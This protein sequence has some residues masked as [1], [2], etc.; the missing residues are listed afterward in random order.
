VRVFVPSAM[1]RLRVV[2]RL[3]AG[4]FA[5]VWLAHDPDLDAPV[6]VKL[7]ADNWATDADVRRRFSDEARLLRRVDSDHLVRVY[8]VGELPDGRPYFVMT[9]ADAGN[10]A[11][12]LDRQP[13]PWPAAEVLRVVDAIAAGLAVLHEHGV[14]HRDLKPR[15]IL[16]RSTPDG[17]PRVLLGDLGIAKDLQWASGITMPAGSDGYMAPEQRGFSAQIG[18]ATDVH[19]LAVTAAQLLGLPGPPWPPTGVGQV[20]AAAT[21]HDPDARTA[22]PTAFAQQLRLAL[23]APPPGPY[24]APPG[25]YPPLPGPYPPPTNAYPPAAPPPP[26]SVSPPFPPPTDRG[27]VVVPREEQTRL[28]GAAT[29]AAG[30]T[31]VGTT[32][33]ARA[34]GRRRLLLVGGVVVLGL[35]LVAGLVGRA[36]LTRDRTLASPDGRVRVGIPHDWTAGDPIPFPGGADLTAGARSADGNRAVSVAFAAGTRQAAE[37]INGVAPTGCTPGSVDDTTVGSWTGV[38]VRYTGCPDGATVDEVVLT[39]RSGGAW[40]VWLE[41]RSVAASPDVA[42]V[43]ASLEVALGREAR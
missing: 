36:Y 32:A 30:T 38:R 2:R 17:P 28:D 16:L 35:V 41:V 15:N 25:P 20:V 43:L 19:A 39:P 3:G 14:V 42:A 27:T 33:A 40:T 24:P 4:G 23:A 26:T 31:A 18:P 8:D 29:T 22:S 10:L 1:G 21:A 5:T 6:A 11:E 7:L 34:T 13:P 37:V 9:Y 12:R